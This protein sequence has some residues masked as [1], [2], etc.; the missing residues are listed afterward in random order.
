M[1]SLF[2]FQ[3][4]ISPFFTNIDLS[5]NT[6]V[7]MT[8]K[9]LA[10][11]LQDESKKSND[12]IAALRR[13][14]AESEEK[15]AAAP[16][17]GHGHPHTGQVQQVTDLQDELEAI[18]AER[19]DLAKEHASLNETLQNTITKLHKVEPETSAEITKLNDDVKYWQYQIRGKDEA[20]KRVQA[21]RS[22]DQSL[23][24]RESGQQT[25]IEKL[26]NDLSRANAEVERL[27][28]ING[29]LTRQLDAEKRENANRISFMRSD[30]RKL[31]NQDDE[32]PLPVDNAALK[33]LSK[34]TFGAPTTTTSPVKSFKTPFI[35]EYLKAKKKE[36]APASKKRKRSAQEDL[37][38]ELADLELD[39]FTAPTGP[40]RKIQATGPGS[41]GTPM[42]IVDG[43]DEELPS[44]ASLVK[45]GK[46]TPKTPLQTAPPLNGFGKRS[47]PDANDDDEDE[48]PHS[49]TFIANTAQ[50]K[51]SIPKVSKL[52]TPIIPTSPIFSLPD[53]TDFPFK[54]VCTY[55]RNG[56]PNNIFYSSDLHGKMADLWDRIAL[57]TNLWESCAGEDWRFEYE[58][59]TRKAK[60]ASCVTRKLQK[61]RMNWHKGE[62]GKYACKDCAKSG[63]PCFTYV[64]LESDEGYEYGEFRL[65][66]LLVSDR[67]REVVKD[68]EIRYWVNDSVKLVDVDEMDEDMEWE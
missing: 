1:P 29:S 38:E 46:A 26:K 44:P 42:S 32:E 16:H 60:T 64:A 8:W 51:M 20:L 50:K 55:Q 49:A 68:R 58:Q 34:Q 36:K 63:R 13:Q 27:K 19:D 25:Q 61:R 33:V 30:P 28:A 52:P 17:T 2:V 54:A 18:R 5:Y 41:F 15:N 10:E 7:N 31:Y 12:T 59:R 67:V 65:L 22:S 9:D 39:G 35:P 3:I 24:A 66:P 62:A 6:N 21:Q 53:I 23:S 11:R 14:L 56:S 43:E 4:P 48:L 45:R 57:T 40:R 37:D 47:S